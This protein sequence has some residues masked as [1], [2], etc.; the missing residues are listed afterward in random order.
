V[1][2]LAPRQAG[3]ARGLVVARL[4]ESS[5]PFS[6]VDHPSKHLRSLREQTHEQAMA[7]V[8]KMQHGEGMS[9]QRPK[10]AKAI[11]VER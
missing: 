6:A 1:E 8:S 9:E 2:G 7:T 5:R 10:V 3:L 4:G 11:S